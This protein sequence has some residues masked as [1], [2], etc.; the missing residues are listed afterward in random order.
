MA[1][2]TFVNCTLTCQALVP[3]R[4]QRLT[5]DN[6]LYNNDHFTLVVRVGGL[7]SGVS[8]TKAWWTVKSSSTDAD[9]GIVQKAVT[10]NA[11]TGSGQITDA[12]ATTSVAVFQFD[13]V[14]ADTLL[15][16]ALRAYFWDCQ[17]EDQQGFVHTAIGDSSLTAGQGVTA[18]TT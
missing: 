11:V 9:P 12:G 10:A 5:A 6:G 13:A 1:I 16:T 15:L 2:S 7:P 4:S 18:A 14:P 17:W 8:A 3:L